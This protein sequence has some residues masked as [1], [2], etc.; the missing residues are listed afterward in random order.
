MRT[1]YAVIVFVVSLA[2]SSLNAHA[3]VINFSGQLDLIFLDAGGAVYSG[4]PLGTNFIGSIDDVT[5]NGSIFDGTT[6][7]SFSCCIAAGGLEVENDLVLDGNA[8]NILNALIGSSTFSGGDLIDLINIEGDTTTASGS[9]I[10][11][12]LSFVFDV[13]TFSDS[14]LSNYPFDPNDLLL[15]LFFIEEFVPREQFFPGGELGIYSAAGE[16]TAI[17]IPAALPLFLSGLAGLGFF[18]WRQRRATA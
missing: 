14:S 6:L 12:G 1:S 16:L 15:S 10:E 5:G 9:R 8:A 11:I 2:I 7:T 13:A 17:P 3:A 18:G 4:V